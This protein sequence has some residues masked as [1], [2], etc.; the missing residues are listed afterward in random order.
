MSH[1]DVLHNE[2]IFPE[3]M[4]FRPERWFHATDQQNR[5]FV[6]FGKGTRM[7][8]GM[9]YVHLC[10]Y[11]SKVR[12]SPPVLTW[13]DRFAYGE[14]YMSLATI[15]CRFDLEL[16]ETSWERDVSY[17]RDCFLGESDRASPGIR[18]KVVADS[19]KFAS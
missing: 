6:P 16:F 5:C 13:L 10:S 19:G 4:R 1:S 8:I 17:T 2:A 14:M 11:S 18:I 12:S 3:P 7:C 9:E 15:L